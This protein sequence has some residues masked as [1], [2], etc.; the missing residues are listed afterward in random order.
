MAVKFIT[1]KMEKSKDIEWIGKATLLS[2]LSD[3]SRSELDA[4]VEALAK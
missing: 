3:S 2:A 1:G 4:L